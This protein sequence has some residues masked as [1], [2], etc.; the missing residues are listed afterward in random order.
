MPLVKTI[1][2]GENRNVCIGNDVTVRV[3]FDGHGGQ[4]KVYISA[5]DDQKIIISDVTAAE[6]RAAESSRLK[7]IP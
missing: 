1:R 5:P 4:V 6:P 7:R 3:D 2:R